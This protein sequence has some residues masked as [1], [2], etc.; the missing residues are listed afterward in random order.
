MTQAAYNAIGLGADL[1][2]QNFMQDATRSQLANALLRSKWNTDL[3]Y[4]GLDFNYANLGENARQFNDSLGFN[5]ANLGEQGRQFDNTLDFNY[6]NADR[7]DM[8]WL[9][10]FDLKNDM[11]NEDNMRWQDQMSAGYLSPWGQNP[12]SVNPLV[13]NQYANN[14]LYGLN[15]NNA[16]AWYEFLGEWLN[17]LGG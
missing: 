10:E 7:D 6:F 12:I 11:F 13:S 2:N 4:A 1:Q 17:G 16:N 8:R 5:Y 14:G 9:S 15:L 3:G